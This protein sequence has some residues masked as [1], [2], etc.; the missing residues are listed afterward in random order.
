MSGVEEDARGQRIEQEASAWL[1]RLRAGGR[2]DQEAFEHWYAADPDHA[3]AYDRVL[4]SWQAINELSGSRAAPVR[5]L[6]WRRPVAIAAIFL[7]A[8]LGLGFLTMRHKSDVNAPTALGTRAGEIRTIALADG[9]RMTLDTESLVHATFDGEQRKVQLVRGRARFQVAAQP[10]PFVIE[11]DGGSVTTSDSTLDVGF[12][13]KTTSVGVLRGNADVRGGLQGA[14]Q[15]RLNPGQ[16]V[17]I[18]KA[19]VSPYSVSEQ[20]WPGRMPSFENAPLSE[21]L[22][23][24]NRYGSA[25]IELAEPELGSLRFT[26]TINAADSAALAHMLATMFKLKCDGTVA[27]RY[28]LSR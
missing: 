5:A 16:K 12:D 20:R 8:L 18:G 9:S 24:A 2:Q 6:D 4:D 22:A 14:V 23:V 28:I 17:M 3:D 21:V 11:T 15:F 27:H 25:R 1:A 7:V 19:G 10:R 13:G 26:G